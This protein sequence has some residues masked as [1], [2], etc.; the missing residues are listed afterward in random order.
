MILFFECA[1][2]NQ[3]KLCSYPLLLDDAPSASPERQSPHISASHAAGC[4]RVPHTLSSF[5]GM[6]RLLGATDTTH[7]SSEDLLSAGTQSCPRAQARNSCW[8]SL[9]CASLIRLFSFERASKG[10]RGLGRRL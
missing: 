1:F 3:C 7:A 4:A 8:Y 5:C 6:W 2:V 9:S 10:T